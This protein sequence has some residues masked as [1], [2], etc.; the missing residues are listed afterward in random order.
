[1]AEARGGGEK[2]K[3]IFSFATKKARRVQ[4]KML[5]KVGKR[6]KTTDDNYTEFVI[7]FNKQ[8]LAAARLQKELQKYTNS[9]KAVSN[10]S[11]TLLD[12]WMELYEPAWKG[13]S[14]VASIIQHKMLLWE[15]L[16]NKMNSEM[17]E[18]LQLYMSKFPETKKLVE[19]RERKIV[20]Y[21]YA[22]K[23]LEETRQKQ[24]VTDIKIQQAEDAYLQAKQAF[25]EVTDV[26]YEE[27][28]TLFDSRIAF[29]SKFFSNVT[30]VETKFHEEMGKLDSQYHDVM[31]SLSEEAESGIHTSRRERIPDSNLSNPYPLKNSPVDDEE[32][33]PSED[34]EVDNLSESFVSAQGNESGLATPTRSLS[35][36]QTPSRTPPSKPIRTDSSMTDTTLPSEGDIDNGSLPVTPK[37]KQP[38]PKPKKPLSISSETELTKTEDLDIVNDTE[39][40]EKKEDIENV[41]EVEVEKAKEVEKVEVK[42]LEEQVEVENVEKVEEQTETRKEEVTK[43]DPISQERE[44]TPPVPD[45]TNNESDSDKTE[46]PSNDQPTILYKLVAAHPYTGEDEDELSF[47]KGDIICVIPFVNPDDEEDGWKMGF[48]EG[49]DHKGLFPENFTKPQQ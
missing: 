36:K 35:D 31:C 49:K 28:P 27:L 34:A 21:D 4:Q 46:T 29:Y 16:L 10:N 48:V 6:E 5:E 8:Q 39:E 19:K 23:Q 1:M 12:L 37:L 47:D 2:G 40:V 17:L 22:K 20:D 38:P 25:D 32:S 41:E 24:K 18:P 44:T 14:E 42:E 30:S 7:N 9:F 33:T 15:D 26:L 45:V 11:R 3:K 13:R 43:E